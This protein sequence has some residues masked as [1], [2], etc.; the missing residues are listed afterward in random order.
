MAIAFDA[1]TITNFFTNGAVT[2]VTISHTTYGLDRLLLVPI[3]ITANA[4]SGVTYAGTV[5]T[6]VDSVQ[7][8]S[9][10]YKVLYYLLNPALGA[11]NIIASY[12]SSQ[13]QTIV[14]G[15]NYTGVK[16]TGGFDTSST[17]TATA[18]TTFSTTLTAAGNTWTMM[19]WRDNNGG[20]VT[21]GSGTT[22]RLASE[23]LCD[24]NGNVSGSTTLNLSGSSR[25]WGGIMVS[26]YEEGVT[27]S[28]PTNLKSYNTNLKANIKSI[29]TNLIANVKTL[30]TNA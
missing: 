19:V 11:N 22:V 20:N 13:S 27:P 3:E 16:K 21:A 15:Y 7:S 29:N 9:D 24:S 18:S 26:F 28:G 23:G 14:G 10:R 17:N 4:V 1:T 5:M 6:Y 25:N 30:D 8:P 2:S 12:S